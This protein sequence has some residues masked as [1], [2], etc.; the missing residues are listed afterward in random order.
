MDNKTQA[1]V[2]Q[3]IERLN[4]TRIV[5]AHRFTTIKNADR[6]FVFSKGSIEECGTYEELMKAKGLFYQLAKAQTI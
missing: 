3:N 6:I 4:A 2:S 1:L 5:I